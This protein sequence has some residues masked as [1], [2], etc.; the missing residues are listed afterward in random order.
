MHGLPLQRP[1]VGQVGLAEAA[2]DQ[3]AR[4]PKDW[5]M[6]VSLLYQTPVCARDMHE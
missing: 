4:P 6:V 5:D 2:G 1:R 3:R